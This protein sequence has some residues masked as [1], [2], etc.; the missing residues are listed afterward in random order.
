MTR[1]A[2][3]APVLP[4]T[5]TPR[6]TSRRAGR[7]IAPIPGRRAVLE[8]LHAA[9]G[10]GTRHI[11]LPLE[12]YRDLGAFA[13]GERPVHP[14]SPPTSASGRS[15][16]RSSAAGLA[17]ADVDF[18]LFTS[19]T[20]IAAPSLDALLVSRLGLRPD[21]K[22]MP[23][24]GL[25]CVAGAAGIARVHDYLLGHPRR[26]RCAALR[27]AVLADPAAR[28]RLDGEHRGQR[29]VRRRRRGRRPGG[30]RAGGRSGW[31][32]RT[33][34][35]RR[36]ALYPDT[37]DVI[38]WDIGGS[39]FRIVLDRR[40]SPTSS[41]GTSRPTSRLPRPR[42][43]SRSPTSARWVAHPGGP[44]VLEA[45]A[46]A[47]DLP[48][49]RARRELAVAR[50]RSG[51]LSSASVLHVLADTLAGRPAG[52]R[53]TPASCSRSGPGVCAELVLL[54]WAARERRR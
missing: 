42:T 13:A 44:Q 14:R 51:N 32:G 40:R 24:F 36:S 12:G 19:V 48:D 35:P 8:R 6:R 37:E 23:S 5:R 15:R 49:E 47:L 11:V 20:G 22:R 53:R 52:A 10:V 3:V 1:I 33:W 29:A 4:P 30:R 21:V 28:R 54:R 25:G 43:S 9:S 50:R 38:G 31:P 34:S 18:L 45:F 27:R 46:R 26:G 16:A 39:G 41:S 17:P 2:A 7:L